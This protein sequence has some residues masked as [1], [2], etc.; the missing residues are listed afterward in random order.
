MRARGWL[1][2]ALVAAAGAASAA[3]PVRSRPPGAPEGVRR[4]AAASNAFGLALHARLRAAPGNLV[5][6]PASVTT[7]LAM[8]WAGARGETADGM[9]RVLRLPGAPGEVAVAAGAMMAGLQ[10]PGQPLTLRMAS[11]LFGDR[12]YRFAPAFL[13]LTREGFRAPL[14]GVDFRGA[15]EPARTRINDWVADRTEGRISE[16]VPPRGVDAET[17]LVLV[18]ALYFLGDWAEPFAREG[19]RPAPFHL[20]AAERADVPTMQRTAVFGHA[21]RDGVQAVE[22]PYRGGSLAMLLLVPDGVDGLEAVERGLTPAWLEGLLAAL[23]PRRMALALPRFEVRPATAV[24]LRAPLEAM[25]MAVAFD[26]RRADFRG[27]ADRRTPPIASS[28]ATCSTRPS[29][30]WTSRGRRRR[31]PPPRS[32]RGWPAWPP[33]RRWSSASTARSCS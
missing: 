17:R 31:P 24:A 20:S 7:A 5:L 29:C 25:G 28:W 23:A 4:L 9:Q 32:C 27:I 10:D 16:L 8:A 2:V 1:A 26:R 14:E 6:S 21:H 33:S 11:R 13:D 22:L 12:R 19:T 3:A 15:P 18:N 30:G